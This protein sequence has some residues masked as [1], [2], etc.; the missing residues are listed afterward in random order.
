MIQCLDEKQ[1]LQ[2]LTKGRQDWGHLALRGN[3][4]AKG[5][6][7]D[8]EDTSSGFLKMMLLKRWDLDPANLSDLIGW[9][10]IVFTGDGEL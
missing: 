4:I 3:V 8:G 7:C 1:G 2:N 10:E 6:C 5:C 9:A